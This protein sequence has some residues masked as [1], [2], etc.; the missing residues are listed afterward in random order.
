MGWATKW[1]AA[2]GAVAVLSVSGQAGATEVD[3][4]AAEA[5]AR[6]ESCLKC[7]AVEREKEGPA[8]KKVAAKYRDKPDAEQTLLKHITAGEIIRLPS[9]G[10]EEQHRIVKT[11]DEK[12]LL[13]L[14]RWILS[15]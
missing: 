1:I 11:K 15:R 9:T 13:N 14:V 3:V 10:E 6:R 2:A 4:E 5:L 12:A 8:Y 7:H